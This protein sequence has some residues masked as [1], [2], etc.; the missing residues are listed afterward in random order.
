MPKRGLLG[1]VD[2]PIP[3]TEAGD[4]AQ[5]E[6]VRLI[7]AARRVLEQKGNSAVV[8]EVIRAV[9]GGE[10][11]QSPQ[12]PQQDVVQALST[13]TQ[14]VTQGAQAAVQIHESAARTAL[15]RAQQAEKSTSEAEQRGESR[16][17][18]MFHHFLDLLDKHNAT[19]DKLREELHQ[20]QIQAKEKEFEATLKAILSEVSSAK[21]AANAA[22]QDLKAENER[23]KKQLEQAEGKK[24]LHEEIAEHIANGT[25]PE[26]R[27]RLQ[28]IIGDPPTARQAA[29]DED[30]QRQL[31]RE[32]VPV[33]A[34]HMRLTL[35]QQREE[36]RQRQELTQ[37]WHQAAQHIT[38]LLGDLRQ[39]V[40]SMGPRFLA[41]GMRRPDSGVPEDFGEESPAE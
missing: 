21:E 33:L 26:Y 31:E 39:L 37:S 15:E 9:A 27:Q 36:Q 13:V 29:Q 10:G 2:Q 1:D 14:A 40:G 17:T 32:A 12:A 24:T 28:G 11:A 8:G 7:Q 38:G 34:E 16:A 5:R 35:A 41:A 19:V 4:E 23:L 22:I 20:A 18:E 6:T 3:R 30:P 25:W